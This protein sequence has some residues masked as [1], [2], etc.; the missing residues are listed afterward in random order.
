M[1]SQ[2]FTTLDFTAPQFCLSIWLGLTLPVAIRFIIFFKIKKF[3]SIIYSFPIE[4]C[5]DSSGYSSR[6]DRQPWEGYPMVKWWYHSPFDFQDKASLRISFF[7]HWRDIEYERWDPFVKESFYKSNSFFLFCFC[8]WEVQWFSKGKWQI[9]KM[10]MLWGWPSGIVVKFAC[11]TLMAQSSW[12]QISGVDIHIAHQAMLW[13]CP[14]YKV[15]E[16]WHKC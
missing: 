8:E 9:L 1:S 5:S 12:V 2:K 14:I 7:P 13:W 4:S 10:F 16:G 3:L 6:C 15:E 11:S